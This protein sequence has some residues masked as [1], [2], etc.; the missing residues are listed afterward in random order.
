MGGER[1]SLNFHTCAGLD[2]NHP[3]EQKKIKRREMV[4]QMEQLVR[5]KESGKT[6]EAKRRRYDLPHWPTVT[7]MIYACRKN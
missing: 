2:T 1:A 6:K 4:E 3:Q 5:K 7:N